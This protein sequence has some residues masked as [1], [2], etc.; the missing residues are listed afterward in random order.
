MPV[1]GVKPKSGCSR[2]ARLFELG[3][4]SCGLPTSIDVLLQNYV[5]GYFEKYVGDL[6]QFLLKEYPSYF[7]QCCLLNLFE[8]NKP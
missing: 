2:V 8:E 6:N 7:W 4:L 3:G 1:L 5:V